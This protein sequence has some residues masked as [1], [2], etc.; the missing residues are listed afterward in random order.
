MNSGWRNCSVEYYGAV[1]TNKLQLFVHFRNMLH[2]IK[3]QTQVPDLILGY[4][5]RKGK[6]QTKQIW[7]RQIY[8]REQFRIPAIEH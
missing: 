2:H 5:S 1:K 6:K 8:A 7:F 4:K 3:C